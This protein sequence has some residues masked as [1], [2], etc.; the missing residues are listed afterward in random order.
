MGRI[1]RYPVKNPYPTQPYSLPNPYSF[2]TLFLTQPLPL[3]P[4]MNLPFAMCYDGA[5][6]KIR[7]MCPIHVVT[8]LEWLY[9][10][11]FFCQ[12]KMG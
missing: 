7:I 9:F 8:P 5:W 4:L 1:M 3:P 2:P 6:E 11:H 10:T 12:A